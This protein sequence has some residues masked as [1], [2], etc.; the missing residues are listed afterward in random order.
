MT[1]E[2][3]HDIDGILRAGRVVARVRDDMLGSLVLAMNPDCP[4][5]SH[6]ILG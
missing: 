2:N 1:V 4:Y 6:F 5:F 3:Q